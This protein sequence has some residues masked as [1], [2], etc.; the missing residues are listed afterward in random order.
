M[1]HDLLLHMLKGT[2]RR[3]YNKYLHHGY[4]FEKNPQEM[5]DE[6]KSLPGAKFERVAHAY[7]IKH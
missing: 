1:Y 5:F 6:H 3:K 4:E 7:T 2:P